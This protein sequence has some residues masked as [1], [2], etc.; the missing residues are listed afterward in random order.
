M[1]VLVVQ[2]RG[3]ACPKRYLGA[4]IK[5]TPR[6]CKEAQLGLLAKDQA[7]TQTRWQIVDQPALPPW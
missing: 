3:A 6:G 1:Q 5:A 2:A 7:S 4:S